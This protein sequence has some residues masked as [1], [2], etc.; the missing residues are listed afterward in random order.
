[1]ENADEQIKKDLADAA[2]AVMALINKAAEGV[3][4]PDGATDAMK[5]TQAALNAANALAVFSTIANED[6]VSALQA[7]V[8]AIKAHLVL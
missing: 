1:M 2:R 4:R 5:L 8:A 6:D 7:D 3:I